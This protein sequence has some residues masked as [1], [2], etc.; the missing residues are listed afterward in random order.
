[1]RSLRK[2]P[3]ACAQQNHATP[4]RQIQTLLFPNY[5]AP[6]Y[7][8]AGYKRRFTAP[9][10]KGMINP[11]DPT[12]STACEFTLSP[13]TY[14][15]MDNFTFHNPTRLH[16]G[17]GQ[18]KALADEIPSTAK[19]LLLAGGGSIKVNGVYDQVT[20]ALGD[21]V[22]FEHWGV[23]ANPDFDTLMPAVELCRQES[24]DW[25]LAVGG[26]SVLD[27]AKF[28]CAAVNYDGDPWEIL[29]NFGASIKS[30]LPLGTVLT[31]PAT[32]SEANSASVISRRAQSEK[33]AFMSPHVFPVFS[34][35]DP[36]TTFSLPKR[37]IENGIG[38]AFSHVVE[39]YLT[40]PTH[41]AVQDEFAESIM[42]VLITEGP[43]SLAAPQDYDARAN[44]VWAAT[45]AL[46][47]LIGCGVPQ[48]WSSHMIGH[49]L[50]ALYGIDHA[51]TLAIVIPSLLTAQSGPKRAKLLQYGARVWGVTEGDEDI[52]LATILAKTREFFE[53]IGLPTRL[54]AYDV[55]ADVASTVATRMTKRGMTAIGE[56][57][58]ITPERI[59]ALLKAAA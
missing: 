12:H 57:S 47:G 28:V 19:V 44:L 41:A 43:K 6:V 45:C 18:I 4:F 26:G 23:E 33:L 52:R 22:V 34:V 48:D 46:Q 54:S 3:L 13:H 40:Y 49:E 31:L 59:E 11:I 38:D 20:T 21:R 8:H 24:I 29:Q 58:D 30:A 16:F 9:T 5:L 32:G 37:Q 36:E 50:T 10:K 1:M 2:W 17:R 25:V 14:P 15:D 51:R 35:L 7:N 55:D 42:R 39:Q 56:H 53:S 27:G